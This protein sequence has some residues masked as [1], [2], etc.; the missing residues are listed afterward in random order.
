MSKEEAN[1]IRALLLQ[2]S[3][4]IPSTGQCLNCDREMVAENSRLALEKVGQAL[5]ILK[6][7][8]NP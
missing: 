3:G 2:A 1:K 4:H 8:L 6:E 5:D 7:Y